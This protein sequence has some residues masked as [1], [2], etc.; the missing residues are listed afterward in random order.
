MSGRLNRGAS[1]ADCSDD[2]SE[3]MVEQSSS[4]HPSEASSEE[5]GYSTSSGNT[6]TLVSSGW[7][8]REWQTVP[9]AQLKNPSSL[10]LSRHQ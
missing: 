6:Q 10:A 8:P 2:S 5:A 4:E 7:Y 1:D 9:G 3:Q